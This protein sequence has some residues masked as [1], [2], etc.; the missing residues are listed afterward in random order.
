MEISE[1]QLQQ[2]FAQ[3]WKVANLKLQKKFTFKTY[4]ELIQF[5][6]K[7]FEIAQKQNHHPELLIKYNSVEVSINNHDE[8]NISNKCNNFANAIDLINFSPSI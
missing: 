7:V 3:N 5:T 4:Q 6:N 1:K 8:K 2:L